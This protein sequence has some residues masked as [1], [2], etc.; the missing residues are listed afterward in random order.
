[1]GAA[2]PVILSI[3]GFDPS[4]GAGIT[5]DVK[6]AAAHGCYAVTCATALTVQSTQGVAAVEAV[7]GSLV[8]ATLKL[9]VEDVEISGIRIGM[10]AT[11]EIATA[12]ADFLEQHHPI[13]VLDPV[14][15]A[16]SGTT[17]TG[18]AAIQVIR[19]RLLRLATV[20]TPNIA[21]AEALT[22]TKIGSQQDMLA[23]AEVLRNLGARN[24]IVTGGHTAENADLLVDE[25]G[26]HYFL[27]GKRIASSNTHGT[28]CAFAT[29]LICNLVKGDALRL[30][31]AKAKQYVS[32]AIAAAHP[33][34]RGPGPLHHLYR[35]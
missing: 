29:A 23:A 1:M 9:L 7:S 27:E 33:L 26:D 3:A 31:A 20:I 24:V 4:S 28:G 25:A 14:L 16:S 30:A 18:E 22:D 15:R 35:G 21:E 32:E 12:V 19:S 11:G 10:L 5:A 34:G 6:T 2:Q 8:R 17:L 13:T